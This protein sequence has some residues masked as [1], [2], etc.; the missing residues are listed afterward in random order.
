MGMGKLEYMIDP[1]Y[2]SVFCVSLAYV[3][4]VYLFSEFNSLSLLFLIQF[5]FTWI[6]FCA[7]NLLI[8]CL[9]PCLVK[10][11]L[12]NYLYQCQCVLANHGPF[13]TLTVLCKC[14][15]PFLVSCTF[16]T[17]WISRCCRCCSS[18]PARFQLRVLCLLCF[19][20]FTQLYC[21]YIV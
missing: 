7:S 1:F 9:W 8:V 20:I 16:C 12:S 15:T 6:S 21:I 2:I 14:L 19:A 13:P 5:M 17:I 11:F 4:C 3:L 10:S 18:I